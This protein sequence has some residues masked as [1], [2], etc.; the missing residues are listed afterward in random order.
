MGNNVTTINTNKILAR[1]IRF[2]LVFYPPCQ[3]CPGAIMDDL[4][5]GQ[6]WEVITINKGIK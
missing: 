1:K 3:I 4:E 2:I 6:W 5:P